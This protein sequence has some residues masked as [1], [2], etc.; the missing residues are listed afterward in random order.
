[1]Q[2]STLASQEQQQCAARRR[3]RPQPAPIS[4]PRPR[5]PT[6]RTSICISLPILRRAVVAWRSAQ[7]PAMH[8]TRLR[9]RSR[10]TSQGR[11]AVP[12]VSMPKTPIWREY[13][14]VSM[15]PTLTRAD[16]RWERTRSQKLA[17]ARRQRP[18]CA[19]RR[20]I[21]HGCTRPPPRLLSARDGLVADCPPQATPDVPVA[22]AGHAAAD[23]HLGACARAGPP[24]AADILV[25]KATGSELPQSGSL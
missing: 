15:R 14:F 8:S 4:T 10:P 7:L 23:P 20:G 22:G 2:V 12:H 3:A 16:A 18:R 25:Q 21:K 9:G 19:A 5:M 17:D 24:V 1:M 13:K 11:S 6:I